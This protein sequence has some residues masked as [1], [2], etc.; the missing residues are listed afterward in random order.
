MVSH[1]TMD[2]YVTGFIRS[3]RQYALKAQGVDSQ[4]VVL[5]VLTKINTGT[6]RLNQRMCAIEK[7]T[8]TY[9]RHVASW[10][11]RNRASRGPRSH[12]EGRIKL[13]RV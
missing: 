11:A 7:T 12:S 2:L 8:N 6:E 3:V 10:V 5:E 13:E 1:G 9:Q 4:R